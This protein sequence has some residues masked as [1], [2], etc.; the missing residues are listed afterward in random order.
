MSPLEKMEAQT[1]TF[2]EF[3]DDN[4]STWGFFVPQMHLFIHEAVQVKVLFIEEPNVSHIDFAN[5]ELLQHSIRKCL[6]RINVGISNK[7]TCLNTV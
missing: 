5:I 7:L 2:G 6:P 3:R 1:M 4:T